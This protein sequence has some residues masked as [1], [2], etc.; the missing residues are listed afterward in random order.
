[1]ILKGH[2]DGQKIILDEP[3]PAGLAPN[4]RVR[5]VIENGQEQSL[6]EKLLDLAVDDDDLPADYAEQH[7]HYVKGTP[8]R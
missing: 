7:D 5:I 4:T 2:F 1:M 3:V 8:K 6:F